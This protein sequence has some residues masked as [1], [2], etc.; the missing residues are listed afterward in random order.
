MSAFEYIP[1]AWPVW[2]TVLFIVSYG[3]FLWYVMLLFF[4]DDEEPPNPRRSTVW[5]RT[6]RSAWAPALL[7]LLFLCLAC[8]VLTADIAIHR[9]FV[10][11]AG[12]FASS[13]IYFAVRRWRKDR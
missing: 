2:L 1:F 6:L 4:G 7:A 10:V 9:S 11:V 8:A 13:M 5:E 3:L 12:F